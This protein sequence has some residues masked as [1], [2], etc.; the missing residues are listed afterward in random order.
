METKG[1][2]ALEDKRPLQT[3]VLSELA[4]SQLGGTVSFDLNSGA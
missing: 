1:F 3:S 2:Q 4:L